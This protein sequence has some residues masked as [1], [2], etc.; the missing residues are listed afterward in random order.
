MG[1]TITSRVKRGIKLLDQKVPDWCDKIDLKRLNTESTYLCVLG[2]VYGTTGHRRASVDTTY[3]KFKKLGKAGYDKGR[4]EL[5]LTYKDVVSYGFE[6]T[7]A[8]EQ[9]Y[10]R[11]TKT[12]VE[13]ILEHCPEVRQ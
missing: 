12:W 2:Q 5:D 10:P 8:S 11:L 9:A 13:A 3:H 1:V 7:G 4:V 6:T